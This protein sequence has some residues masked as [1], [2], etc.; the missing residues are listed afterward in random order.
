MH[1]RL[2]IN[3]TAPAASTVLAADGDIKEAANVVSCH[4]RKQIGVVGAVCCVFGVGALSAQ[5]QQHYRKLT[6]RATFLCGAPNLSFVL[7]CRFYLF[8]DQKMEGLPAEIWVKIFGL[9]SPGQLARLCL[10]C[11]SWNQFINDPF[12]VCSPSN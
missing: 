4:D 3:G 11:T 12:L 10:V 9:L 7:V 8:D 6:I 5:K 2:V 1:K